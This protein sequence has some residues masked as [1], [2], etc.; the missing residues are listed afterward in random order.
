MKV[1]IWVHKDDIIIGEIRKHYFQCPQPGY[2]NYVQVEVTR[3]E[4][5]QLR[6]RQTEGTYIVP[7]IV[8]KHKTV[9]GGDFSEWWTSLTKEEQ[10]TIKKYY[11]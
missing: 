8:K 9:T 6:D 10:T 5:V 1:I 11:E 4:F 7:D 2:Q 3:D